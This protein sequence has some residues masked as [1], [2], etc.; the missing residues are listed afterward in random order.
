MLSL[1]NTFGA[2]VEQVTKDVS[3]HWL[4]AN[5][6]RRTLALSRTQALAD[7]G[8]RVAEVRLFALAILWLGESA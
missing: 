5:I 3:R 2:S 1:T 4:F 6:G 7:A 8:T